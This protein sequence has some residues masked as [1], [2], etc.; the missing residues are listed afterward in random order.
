MLRARSV[1]QIRRQWQRIWQQVR[2]EHGR[3][4]DSWRIPT[5]CARWACSCGSAASCGAIPRRA[6]P[7]SGRCLR[8][9]VALIPVGEQDV[10]IVSSRAGAAALCRNQK[11]AARR[12]RLSPFV[13]GGRFEFDRRHARFERRSSGPVDR[14]VV[15]AL[16]SARAAALAL[17][18]WLERDW[19]RCICRR[20]GSAI[21]RAI[22]P[23]RVAHG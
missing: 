7:F 23:G 18:P 2:A 5:P 22:S 8:E 14:L 11:R 12:R 9:P 10:C 19:A 20:S 3:R 13:Q 6:W 1:V 21:S 15:S 16:A 17:K 4:L